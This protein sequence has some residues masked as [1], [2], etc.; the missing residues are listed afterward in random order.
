MPQCA[1]A[2]S[3]SASAIRSNCGWASSYQKSWSTA[4]PRVQGAPTDAE[5][6]TG[7]D[8][9]PSRSPGGGA[10]GAPGTT[11][12]VAAAAGVAEAEG[13]AAAAEVAALAGAARVA[14]AAMGSAVSA[15]RRGV[16]IFMTVNSISGLPRIR[17]TI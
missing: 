8:T 10:A 9:S 2:Q 14:G 15:S 4:T 16:H 13:G 12:G 6:D 3:G 1:I 7:K 11:A 5:Q 17:L